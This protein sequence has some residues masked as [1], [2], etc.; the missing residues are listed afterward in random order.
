MGSSAKPRKKY[1]P[2][3]VLVNPVGYVLESLMPVRNHDFDMV[4]LK[5]KNSEAMVALLQGR[6]KKPDMNILIAMSNIVE[7]LWGL[8]FGGEFKDVSIHGK[9]ALLSIVQRA[10][11]HG[12]FTP[13]GVEIKML[14]ELMELH[15]AQM[16]VITVK[17]MEKAVAVVRKRLSSDKH[18]VKLPT[19]P[20]HLKE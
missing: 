17:D 2:K 16:E 15:D 14:N 1:R 9:T 11:T 19:V 8:G 4:A 20:D 6:A 12:R 7:A 5:I 18:T 10:T 13:T 3:P